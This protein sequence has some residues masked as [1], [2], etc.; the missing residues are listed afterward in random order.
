[1]RRLGTLVGMLVAFLLVGA[2]Q[3]AASIT[4]GQLDPGVPSTE[5]SGND[6]TDELQPTVTSGNSYV[7]PASGT[8]TSWSNKTAVDPGQQLTFK[9]YRPNGGSI[10]TVVGHDGPRLLTS[11]TVNT[12]STSIPVVAGDIIGLHHGDTVTESTCNF[13]ATDTFFERDGNLADGQFGDFHDYGPGVCCY[14]RLNLTAVFEPTNSFTVG[15][16][17]RDKKKGTG[18][19]NLTVPNSGELTGSG[20]GAKVSSTRAVTSKSV[21]AGQAQLLIKAKGKKKRKLNETGKVK[22]NV[23]VTYTP[24]GG[25]PNAQSVKVKLKKDV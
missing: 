4:L 13:A 8:I 22:L 15:Q 21:G 12:F 14:Y 23:A 1:M 25:A 10:Y 7:V 18:T 9:V 2:A 19:I 11:S 20:K 24:T 3:A 5:C 16:V 17:R 6:P